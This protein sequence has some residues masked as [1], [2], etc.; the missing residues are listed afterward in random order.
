MAPSARHE[1][2]RPMPRL[3]VLACIIAMVLVG[4]VV[5]GVF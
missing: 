1:Y 2:H 5:L 4:L 3:G